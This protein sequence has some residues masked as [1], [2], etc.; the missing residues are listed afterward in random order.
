MQRLEKEVSL[1]SSNSW[2]KFTLFVIILFLLRPDAKFKGAKNKQ[3]HKLFLN[4]EIIIIIIIIIIIVDGHA[5]NIF[6][7]RMFES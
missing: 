3:T 4:S 7:S 2:N 1:Y 5:F 6:I